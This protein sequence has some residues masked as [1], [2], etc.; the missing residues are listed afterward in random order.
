MNAANTRRGFFPWQRNLVDLLHGKDV[1]MCY[2]N[3]RDRYVYNG[4]VQPKLCDFVTLLGYLCA[5]EFGDMHVFDPLDRLRRVHVQ[6]GSVSFSP[7]EQAANFIPLL[8]PCDPGRISLNFNPEKDLTALYTHM[9][10]D[11]PDEGTEPD[12]GPQV[13]CLVAPCPTSWLGVRGSSD[14]ATELRLLLLRRLLERLGEGRKIV[15]T[16]LTEEDIPKS[17]YLNA[18]NVAL[19]NI[20]LPDPEERRTVA[21]LRGLPETLVPAYANLTEGLSTR[22]TDRVLQQTPRFLTVASLAQVEHPGQVERAIQRYKF[23]ERPDYYEQLSMTRLQYADEFFTEGIVRDD[24]G[25]GV[26]RIPGVMGQ[27]DAVEATVNMLWRAK[28]NVARFLR[29]PG[30]L[31]PRGIM[32]YCGPSGTGKTMLAKRIARFLFDSEE[33]FTRFDMSEYMQD[34]AVSRLIGAPPGYVG[35]DRGGQLTNAVR[36]RPFSVILFDEVEKAHPRVL[37]VFL[38]ILSDGRLTDSHGQTAYLSEAIIVFTSN[39]GMRSQRTGFGPSGAMNNPATLC[40]ELAEYTALMQRRAPW[41]EVR[42]HFLRSVNDFYEREISRPEL[43]NRFGSN[44]S[45]FQA[46]SGADIVREMFHS[47][48]GKIRERF[49]QTY[50]QQ[51]LVLEI[52]KPVLDHLVDKHEEGVHHFGGRA[53][54]NALE[55]ELLTPLARRILKIESIDRDQKIQVRMVHGEITAD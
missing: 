28:A 50:T 7:V 23:G 36:K 17:L 44:I 51:N 35:S 37:D 16:Y 54:V 34:F 52:H 9:S 3:V 6:A 42:D 8:E 41:P 45:A 29:D 53:V 30:S 25:K 55:D 18:P 21:R 43:R 20:P 22:E 26:E 27:P 31:P 47:Y 24:A 13:R 39:I 12:A 40:D 14:D 5:E 46:V 48:L 2:G 15:L 10:Q 1:L 19:I 33:A 32:F 38:Q 11:L 4:D 49:A